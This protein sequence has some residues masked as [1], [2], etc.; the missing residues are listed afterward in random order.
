MRKILSLALPLLFCL[1]GCLKPVSTGE[2]LNSVVLWEQEDSTVASYIDSVLAAFKK[3]PGNEKLKITR[4]HYGNEELRQQF[5]AASIAGSPP[6]LIMGPSDTAGVYAISGFILPVDEIFDMAKYNKAVVEA[7]RLDG[8]TWGVPMS[9][10]N[11]LLFMVNKKLSPK[12]PQD[13]DELFKICSETVKSAKTPYCMAFDMGEP[14]WLMPWLGGYGGWPLENRTPTLDTPAMR[15]AVNFYLDM[16]FNRK[17]VPQECDYNCMDSLFKESQVPFIINGDWAITSYTDKFGKDFAAARI[18]K[19]SSTGLWPSPMVSGK[20]FMLSAK[21][22]GEKLALIKRLIEF[23]T[24]RQNQVA[25]ITALKR[26]PALSAAND[27]EAIVKDPV[28]SGSMAQILVG[29]P[30]PMAT[31][32]RAVWDSIR[33]YLSRIMNQRISA[34]EGVRRMQ[35]DCVGKIREMDR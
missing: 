33:P 17:F 35:T 25:Q 16:K 29:K 24:N 20:Y 10:G 32:M 23:Y 34:D 2:D 11:H 1:S 7:V 8:K 28:L 22:K 27:A 4:V 21:L 31:E 6:D 14:F 9:N 30:M 19:I 12:I 26:L 3:L 15:G 5:Q 18:P 13:T